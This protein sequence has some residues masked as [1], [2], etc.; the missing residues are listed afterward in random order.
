MDAAIAQSAFGFTRPDTLETNQ[1]HSLTTPNSRHISVQSVSHGLVSE[2]SGAALRP[3]HWHWIPD[4]DC[5]S[6]GF[7]GDVHLC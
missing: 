4:Y 1:G 7:L 3:S 5:K 2:Q 6:G